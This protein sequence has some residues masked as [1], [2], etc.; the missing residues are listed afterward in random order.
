MSEKNGLK[1]N[2]KPS[3]KPV[4]KNHSRSGQG[5]RNGLF[6]GAGNGA[7]RWPAVRPVAG[8]I[9]A[10]VLIAA[11][12]IGLVLAHD[13]LTQWDYFRA[14]VVTVEG[15]RQ[16]EEE[17]VLRQARVGKGINILSVNLTLTRKR[18]LAH[19]WIAEAEVGRELPS[20]LHIR[21][22]E[23]MP[24]AMLDMGR[25]FLINLDGEIFKEYEPSDRLD[26][27]VVKGLEYM[28]IPLPERLGSEAFG[29]V[30]TVLAMG[31]Q[32]PTVLSTADIRDI[33]VDREMGLTL[34][35]PDSAPG[36]FTAVKLGYDERAEGRGYGVKYQRLREIIDFLEREGAF[37]PID[38]IDLR[39]LDRIVVQPGEGEG[40]Q[41]ESGRQLI[42]S[43]LEDQKE[44]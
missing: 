7:V 25:R 6:N 12:S 19:P 1:P 2:G 26:V 4:R 31:R 21:I 18:L 27:P 14:E 5:L 20:G 13:F 42:E 24:L 16:L 36:P 40:Q 38:A 15:Y 41:T 10:L 17:E 9:G 3:R 8:V 29:A 34:H 44:V 28:D 11:M 35:L 37:L 43:R 39:D 33:R 23:H 22:Q 30:M 32:S